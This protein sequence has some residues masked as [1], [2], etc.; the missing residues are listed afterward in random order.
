[1]RER[2]NIESFDQ[3]IEQAKR[4][5]AHECTTT[6]SNLLVNKITGKLVIEHEIGYMAPKSFFPSYHRP[7]FRIYTYENGELSM[8]EYLGFKH[9]NEKNRIK[10]AK[11]KS[12]KPE[13][14]PFLKLHLQELRYVA[15]QLREIG[16][17]AH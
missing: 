13:E 10:D 9:R 6:L 8:H 4:E 3:K 5:L 2:I 11:P 12:I 15:L 7:L 14:V 1:M 17:S 16:T